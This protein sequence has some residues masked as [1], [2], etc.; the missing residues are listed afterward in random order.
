MKKVKEVAMVRCFL[1]EGILFKRI[2]IIDKNDILT[3]NKTNINI[4]IKT[5]A[6]T[7]NIILISNPKNQFSIE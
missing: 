5:C 6:F 3:D 7:K 1:L 4:I 2:H